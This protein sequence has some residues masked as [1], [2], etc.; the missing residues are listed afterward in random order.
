[1]TAHATEHEWAPLGISLLEEG[2]AQEKK[3]LKLTLTY[4]RKIPSFIHDVFIT[5]Q[6]NSMEGNPPIANSP[7]MDHLLPA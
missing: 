2:K 1:M 4:L 7:C 6:R 5:D 3:G